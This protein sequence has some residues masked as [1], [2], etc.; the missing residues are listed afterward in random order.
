[1]IRLALSLLLLHAA[2]ASAAPIR[3][4]PVR[5]SILNALISHV[6]TDAQ[7]GPTLPPALNFRADSAFDLKLLASIALQDDFYSKT[8]AALESAQ[9][10]VAGSGGLLEEFRKALRDSAPTAAA[11]VAEETRAIAHK[12]SVKSI[13]PDD[14][15]TAYDDLRR[16]APLGFQVDL[17]LKP[18]RNMAYIARSQKTL[19]ALDG[20]AGAL[21]HG[22]VPLPTEEV[23]PGVFFL[24]KPAEGFTG[25]EWMIAHAQALPDGTAEAALR[26]PKDRSPQ[27]LGLHIDDR[28][29]WLGKIENDRAD[30]VTRDPLPPAKA[31]AEICRVNEPCGMSMTLRVSG[32]MSANPETLRTSGPSTLNVSPISS[33]GDGRTYW[34]LTYGGRTGQ[35]VTRNEA[36]P[37]GKP[38]LIRIL[39]EASSDIHIGSYELAK[40]EDFLA[41]VFS[42]L[43]KKAEA[44]GKNVALTLAHARELAALKRAFDE[45]RVHLKH[46]LDSR[47]SEI[48]DPTS[49]MRGTSVDLYRWYDLTQAESL[50]TTKVQL[51]GLNG[52]GLLE[53][54]EF[55]ANPRGQG[56]RL[57]RLQKVHA[58]AAAIRDELYEMIRPAV[59]ET[60]E[61]IA[62]KEGLPQD[63]LAI[64]LDGGTGKVIFMNHEGLAP[65][66]KADRVLEQLRRHAVLHPILEATGRDFWITVFKADVAEKLAHAALGKEKN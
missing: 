28:V 32:L 16:F 14:V 7:V 1:M 53:P 63:Q 56:G 42:W 29:Y 25:K 44:E 66:E 61:R 57:A 5:L 37:P 65:E 23:R 43:A 30:L 13:S 47:A 15:I 27:E 49:R 59:Q 50:G 12:V 33:D 24:R 22:E 19:A 11:L 36:T 17:A 60:L 39:K 20:I 2:P 58:R 31:R 34:S 54:V 8:S 38:D 51:M 46:S 64:R 6:R 10:W 21:A 55:I 48:W 41:A 26:I 62:R 3:A 4:A 40:S 18:L 9:A 52:G 35:L 45:I